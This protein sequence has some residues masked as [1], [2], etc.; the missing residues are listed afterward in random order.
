MPPPQEVFDLA[1]TNQDGVVD[2]TELAASLTQTRE[3]SGGDVDV[4]ELLAALD[5]D[6]DGGVSLNEFLNEDGARG[7][8][9]GDAQGPAQYLASSRFAKYRMMDADFWSSSESGVLSLMA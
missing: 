6:D 2:A 9:G 3:G 5:T 7:L 8:S 1:D 4:E